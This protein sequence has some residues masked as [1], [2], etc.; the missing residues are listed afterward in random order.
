MY[1]QY[2]EAEQVP[3]PAAERLGRR[4]P[5]G[6]AISHAAAGDRG[7]R[8]RDPRAPCRR[9]VAGPAEPDPGRPGPGAPP[10]D[11]SRR[12]A[13]L[14]AEPTDSAREHSPARANPVREHSA[15]E[16]RS[17]RV[18]ARARRGRCEGPA[19]ARARPGHATTPTR[20]PAPG[21]AVER[22]RSGDGPRRAGRRLPR[23]ARTPTD[24][25]PPAATQERRLP[26][27]DRR[28][29]AVHP[30]TP[31]HAGNRPGRARGS[32]P[33]TGRR[34]TGRRRNRRPTRRRPEGPRTKRRGGR[35]GNRR[36]TRHRCRT[37]RPAER[38]THDPGEEPAAAPPKRLRPTPD[39]HRV[40]RSPPPPPQQSC[41]WEQPCI[42]GQ[43]RHIAPVSP[44]PG[45]P[46]P[47]GSGNR[48]A[49]VSPLHAPPG[50]AVS[51]G[52]SANGISG[53]R[54]T[55]RTVSTNGIRGRWVLHPVTAGRPHLGHRAR[56]IYSLHIHTRMGVRAGSARTR[57]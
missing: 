14:R 45:R 15:T 47:S 48:G 9:R 41:W 37:P 31:A 10:A 28:I 3:A 35:R 20:R 55:G 6:P 54:P 26:V 50:Y 57:E 2:G 38:P 30:R 21:P 24:R 39:A 44:T 13:R 27:A 42:Y 5:A 29:P 17:G 22:V 36:P 56:I 25:G 11:R 52:F 19:T 46:P 51:S 33:G 43:F 34:R 8:A 23:G 4:R 12:P 53:A 49:H 16:T 1:T 32:S 7:S 18:G 40:P